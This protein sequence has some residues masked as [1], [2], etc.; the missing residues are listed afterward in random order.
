MGCEV[1][2]MVSTSN[3]FQL[4]A[5]VDISESELESINCRFKGKD[6]KKIIKM[7][8]PDVV[9][10]FTIPRYALENTLIAL[11]ENVCAVVG[12]T[13]LRKTDLD[14]IHV[15]AE[16]QGVGVLIAPNF[17][18]GAV[19]MMEVSKQIAKYFHDVEII[20]MHNPLKKDSPSG[21]ALKTL[22][23]IIMNRS[24]ALELFDKS[25]A[26]GKIVDN[27]PVHSI[28][29]PGMVAHQEVIFGGQ[30]QTLTIRHDS[31]DRTS[32]MPGVAL[33]IKKIINHK[34]MIYGLENLLD[35]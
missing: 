3:E 35:S 21:T 11:D 33:A 1:V 34:G 20:E 32:F 10:D 25:P 24:K 29:L 6:L 28:R 7:S 12:T 4:V 15:C 5:A 23:G 8:K 27:I 30:G 26:R 9:V 13:G 18:I 17:A 31:Y 19:L 14:K 2:K 22:D 16:S